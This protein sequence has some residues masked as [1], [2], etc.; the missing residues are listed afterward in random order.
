MAS[1]RKGWSLTRLRRQWDRQGRWQ[2]RFYGLL[3]LTVVTVSYVFVPWI[4]AKVLDMPG[5]TG[6][7]YEPKDYERQVHLTRQTFQIGPLGTFEIL[8]VALLV[9]V[10]CS[11]LTYLTSVP[12]WRSGPR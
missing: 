5:Y 3:I 10:G 4:A 9:L 6:N 1:R 11:W 12:R 2:V 7:F 8:K